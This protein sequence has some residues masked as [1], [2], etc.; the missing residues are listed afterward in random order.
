MYIKNMNGIAIMK[1]YVLSSRSVVVECFVIKACWCLDIR[2]AA[3]KDEHR[4]SLIMD[5]INLQVVDVKNNLRR[6][7]NRPS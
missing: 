2:L 4:M 3:S 6:T 5:S 1:S 7:R